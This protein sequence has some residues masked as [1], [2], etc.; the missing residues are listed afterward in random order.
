MFFSSYFRCYVLFRSRL[1]N[2]R[3]TA[4]ELTVPATIDRIDSTS[5]KW[6]RSPTIDFDLYE[7]T[8][9]TSPDMYSYHFGSL[10]DGDAL[11]DQ[12]CDVQIV[13]EACDTTSVRY[14]RDAFP[15]FNAEAAVDCQSIEIDA[16]LYE[17]ST[18]AIPDT[19]S[20]NN[21]GF[22]FRH[23]ENSAPGPLLSILKSAQ[24]IFLSSSDSLEKQIWN[25]VKG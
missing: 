22:D 17:S 19:S 3:H 15:I 14:D 25:A 13:G 21:K 12:S 7:F 1:A 6:N 20:G 4:D 24:S 2:A 5:N 8:T 11:N 10:N 9:N 18:N 16:D 23:V